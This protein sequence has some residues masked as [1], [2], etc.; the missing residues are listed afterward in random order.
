MQ[1]IFSKGSESAKTEKK[2]TVRAFGTAI[3]YNVGLFV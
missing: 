1:A 3:S 2:K